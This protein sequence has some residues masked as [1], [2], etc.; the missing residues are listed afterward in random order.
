MTHFKRKLFTIHSWFGLIT[1]FFLLL[2]GLSGSLLVFLDELDEAI[3]RKILTVEPHTAP[4][5]LDSLYK[6]ITRQYPHLN[7][8][9]WTNPGA[10]QDQSYQFRLYGNDGRLIS[11]DLGAINLNPY[12]GEILRQGRSDDLEVGW[13]Q[14]IFQFHFSF[15][16]GMPGEALAAVLGLTMLISIATGTFVYRKFFWKTLLFRTKINRKNWR[17]ISSDL[18]RMAGV[19]SLALNVV[20][21]FTGFWMNLFAFKK[22]IWAKEMRPTPANT[23]FAQSFDTL[24]LKAR[25]TMPDLQPDYVYLPTQPARKFSVRGALKNESPLFISG[26]AIHFDAQTGKMTSLYR[27]ADLPFGKKMEALAYPLHIGNFGGIG[28]KILYIIVGLTPGVLSI[29]GFILWRR[30]K[31]KRSVSDIPVQ[32]PKN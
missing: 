15:H 17:T 16:L 28:L 32:K 3:Y 22:D 21:F 14:W 18:H 10:G 29:T 30:L 25:Q 2:L 12:T 1:G 6:I 26:N 24:L 9:A 27:Y 31:K 7:G 8:V 20:I 11:Y 5:P 4:L 13:M 19:W 23:V